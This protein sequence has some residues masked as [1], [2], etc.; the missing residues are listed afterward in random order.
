MC[1]SSRI[2]NETLIV[3]FVGPYQLSLERQVV[4][5]R[6]RWGGPQRGTGD[7]NHR[8]VRSLATQ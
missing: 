6:H 8:S 3:V 1:Q 4:D 7:P 5:L 2:R